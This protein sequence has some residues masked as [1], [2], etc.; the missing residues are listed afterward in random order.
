M[1]VYNAEKYLAESLE[2][3]LAQRW[4]NKEIIIV[5]DGSVDN[6]LEIAK[7]FESDIL[8]VFSQENL[9]VCKARNSCFEKCGGDYIQYLDADDLLHPEKISAQMEYL[10]K[11]NADDKRM[12]YGK[13]EIFDRNIDVLFPYPDMNNTMRGE[14]FENPYDLLN[15][16]FLRNS[17]VQPFAWLTPRTLIEA[18]GGWDEE[19]IIN[20]D[21]EFF[22]RVL[23]NA[24]GAYYVD[25]S[26]GYYRMLRDSQSK[27]RDAAQYESE[28]RSLVKTC[29]VML[30]GNDTAETRKACSA[31]LSYYI[32]VWYPGNMPHLEELNHFMKRR[33][34]C[35]DMSGR[36]VKFKMAAK[37]LGWYKALRMKESRK[38]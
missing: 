32:D 7:S 21:G 27:Q 19:L 34:L 2:S 8:K 29:T 24:S 38:G 6:S 18:S 22:S 17:A 23:R 25:S 9:G 26:I 30:D 35:Y 31:I 11:N 33:G 36:G 4:E 12:V 20:T 14:S 10:E 3:A 15:A 28:Y 16:M 5:D 1:P 37:T 13:S